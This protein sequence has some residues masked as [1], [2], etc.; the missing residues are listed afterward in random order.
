MSLAPRF[1]DKHLDPLHP[2]F[3]IKFLKDTLEYTI[4]DRRCSFENNLL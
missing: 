2:T 1:A 3:Y 4:L